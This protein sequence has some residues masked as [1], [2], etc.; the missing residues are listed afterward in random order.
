MLYGNT[1]DRAYLCFK[2]VGFPTAGL[3]SLQAEEQD[4]SKRIKKLGKTNHRFKNRAKIPN[5]N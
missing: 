2:P 4:F 5:L 1:Q 3:S